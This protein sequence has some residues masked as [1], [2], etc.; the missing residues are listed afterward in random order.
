MW[1]KKPP[2]GQRYNEKCFSIYQAIGP[3]FA[4]F[5]VKFYILTLNVCVKSFYLNVVLGKSFTPFV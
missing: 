3:N 1:N 5:H 2:I 4:Y